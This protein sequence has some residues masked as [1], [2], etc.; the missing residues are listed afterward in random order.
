M[1]TNDQVKA[2]LESALVAADLLTASL[3]KM[4]GE[5]DPPIFSLECSR[6]SSD[7]TWQAIRGM[8]A[9]NRFWPVIVQREPEFNS[10]NEHPAVSRIVKKVGSAGTK[11]LKKLKLFKGKTSQQMLLKIEAQLAEFEKHGF[12]SAQNIDLNEIFGTIIEQSK[13]L[14]DLLNEIAAFAAAAPNSVYPD[15]TSEAVVPQKTLDDIIDSGEDLDFA[16][17]LASAAHV[18]GNK[19]RAELWTD[20]SKD[21]RPSSSPDENVVITL[22]PTTICWRVPAYLRFGDFGSCPPPDVHL[23]ALKSWNYR[24]EAEVVAMNRNSVELKIN[25]PV[26]DSKEAFNIAN[27]HLIYC[28]DFVYSVSSSLT[29]YAS[30]LIGAESWKFHWV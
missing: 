6:A 10:I 16:E 27:E 11:E 3:L 1:S 26:N 8:V 25:K 2:E 29:N 13:L 24:F 21:F 19:L 17:W 14:P 4:S 23:A 28:P 18:N 12:N 22:I 15:S 20:R 9:K 5:N 30:R 7:E